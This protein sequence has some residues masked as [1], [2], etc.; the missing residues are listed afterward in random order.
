MA[1]D[2]RGQRLLRAKDSASEIWFCD[3]GVLYTYSKDGIGVWDAVED[4]I[5]W[6]RGIQEK[7]E[8]GD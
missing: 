8:G 1:S 3:R 4:D 2:E 6:V 7:V 5:F